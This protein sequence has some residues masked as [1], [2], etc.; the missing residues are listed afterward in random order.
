MSRRTQHT[1]TAEILVQFHVPGMPDDEREVA[2]TEVEITYSFLPECGPTGPT[3][4]SGGEPGYPAETDLISAKLIKGDG[5]SPTQ[6][7]VNEWA[8][9]WLDDKGYATACHNAGQDNDSARADAEERRAEE[10]REGA[11]Q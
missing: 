9:G 5:L 10:Q 4:S 8:S 7:Q 6:E 2:N 11:W 3:Y 1:I